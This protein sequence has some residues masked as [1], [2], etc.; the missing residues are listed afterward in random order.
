[1]LSIL[2]GRLK[3]LGKI[4]T[5]KDSKIRIVRLEIFGL[6]GMAVDHGKP[7][8]IVF[9]S[10]FTGRVGTESPYLVI[11]SRRMV[12]QLRLVK[13]FIQKLHNLIPD[14]HPDTDIHGSRCGFYPDLLTF[15]PEPV[16]PFPAH[17]GYHFFSKE[18]FFLMGLYSHGLTVL[19]QNFLHHGVELK[20]DSLIL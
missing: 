12:D 9:R 16:S 13:V 17:C 15:I 10:H 1:M 11:K 2:N 3:R 8:F 20:Y 18:A 7:A 5:H 6:I 14:F 4:L 19:H